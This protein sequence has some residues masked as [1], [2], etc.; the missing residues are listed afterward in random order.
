MFYATAAGATSSGQG[1]AYI[2]NPALAFW[3][4]YMT[5]NAF[6]FNAEVGVKLDPTKTDSFIGDVDGN[7]TVEAADLVAYMVGV[8][9][10]GAGSTT[11][12]LFGVPYANIIDADSLA[13]YG[14]T[15]GVGGTGN[16]LLK[17][18]SAHD[19]VDTDLNAGGRMKYTITHGDCAIPA[20]VTIY[21]N[22]TLE[23][24]TT[25]NCAG[26]GYHVTPSWD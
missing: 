5:F 26:D 8:I 25:D 18:D 4:N 11:T 3:G 22:A 10:Q 13:V 9:G 16:G 6:N 20:D 14:A 7:G 2:Y 23:R 24:C 1:P 21:F 19:L 12:T 17:N 15:G